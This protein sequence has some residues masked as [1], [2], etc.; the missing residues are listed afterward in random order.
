MSVGSE[1]GG[2]GRDEKGRGED[3]KNGFFGNGRQLLSVG[4]VCLLTISRSSV[5]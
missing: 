3:V 1:K 2:G 4:V 5:R